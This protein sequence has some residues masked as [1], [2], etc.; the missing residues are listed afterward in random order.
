MAQ[1]VPKSQ[2]DYAKKQTAFAWHK[3]YEQMRRNLESE[4]AYYQRLNSM[5]QDRMVEQEEEEEKYIITQL[6]E[7]MVELK[8]KIECP[9]CYEDIDPEHLG[10]SKCGHK[11]C[12]PCLD[13]LKTSTKKCAI[14]N[15][16][17]C[18]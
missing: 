6:K 7:L 4:R 15:K 17:L 10:I 11:F 16:K 1:M 3:Y 5:V 14:C 8:K 9:I 13:R 12:Q 18:K 2:L